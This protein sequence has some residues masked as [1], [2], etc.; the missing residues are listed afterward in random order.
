[1]ERKAYLLIYSGASI[2][3]EQVKNWANSETAVITW[4]YDLPN[5]F[6]L[7]SEKSAQELSNSLMNRIGKARF[8]ITE[9]SANRQGYLP[10]DTW[11]LFRNKKLPEK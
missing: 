7:I 3:R 9:V 10:K 1:M 8:L 5:S 6:Y 11:Y 4:R 2:T